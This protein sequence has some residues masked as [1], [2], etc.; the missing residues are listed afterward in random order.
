[1]VTHTN[2][3]G[4]VATGKNRR[5]VSTT[6]DLRRRLYFARP[7]ARIVLASDHLFTRGR[8]QRLERVL[9]H[10]QSCVNTV[11]NRKQFT[12]RPDIVQCKGFASRWLRLS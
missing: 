7:Y 9:G 2:S 4:V 1:M 3:P 8:F 5:R 12:N 6:S 11:A 10:S